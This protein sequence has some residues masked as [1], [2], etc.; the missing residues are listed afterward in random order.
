[1]GRAGTQVMQLHCT[2]ISEFLDGLDAL[3]PGDQDSFRIP[4]ANDHETALPIPRES[5][6]SPVLL[7]FE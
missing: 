6:P 5:S 2:S 1:M 3:C 4:K 7:C